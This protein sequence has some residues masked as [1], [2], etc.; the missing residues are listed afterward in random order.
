VQVPVAEFEA[1]A[2][3]PAS[4]PAEGP[5]E[6]AF[7][8]R[9]NV[10]KS[11]LINLLAGRRGLARTSTTPGR[12]RG[13]VFFRLQPAGWPVVRL[14]DLP[15]YGYA[16]ASK[17]EREAWQP[18]VEGY[19]ERRRTLRLCV[20]LVDARRGANEADRELVSWL[21]TLGRPL[22]VVQTKIDELPRPRRVAAAETL[23]RGLDLRARPLAFSTLEKLGR[24]ELWA[25]IRA[26]I[27]A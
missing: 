25:A 2:V 9:S 22:V 12:T 17:R 3:E 11:S 23:R 27:D 10:G 8:G 15:G 20:V 4:W 26:A 7:C 16:R 18:M 24:D 1:L 6:V 5:P 13:L 14:V 21:G 19:I